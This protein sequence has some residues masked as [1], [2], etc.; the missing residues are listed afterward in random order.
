MAIAKKNCQTVNCLIGNGS[1]GWAKKLIIV[2]NHINNDGS[3]KIV[4]ACTLPLTAIKAVNMII[5]ELAVFTFVDVGMAL[6]EFMP[7]ATLEDVR[8]KTEATFSE[9]LK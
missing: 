3:S 1:D 5:T 6:T 9:R 4:S 7:G 8:N 2:M